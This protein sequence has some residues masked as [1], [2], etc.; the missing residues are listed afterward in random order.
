M[1]KTFK[2][3]S[4]ILLL[5]G[6]MGFTGIGANVR[7]HNAAIQNEPTIEDTLKEFNWG[8]TAESELTEEEKNDFSRYSPVFQSLLTPEL[9]VELTKDAEEIKDLNAILSNGKLSDGEFVYGKESVFFVNDKRPFNLVYEIQDNAGNKYYGFIDLSECLANSVEKNIDDIAEKITE[10]LFSKLECACKGGVNLNY[11]FARALVNGE[12]RYNNALESL[13]A[14]IKLSDKGKETSNQLRKDA[15][16]KLTDKTYDYKKAK[17]ELNDERTFTLYTGDDV[18][19]A[20]R[21]DSGYSDKEQKHFCGN[22][23]FYTKTENPNFKQHISAANYVYK[24][25]EG[26]INFENVKYIIRTKVEEYLQR[27]PTEDITTNHPITNP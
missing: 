19:I 4:L 13:V 11:D 12:G 18:N 2:N 23:S 14:S 22:L 15:L 26:R 8:W 24:E 3:K 27:H 16:L 7:A 17:Y 5:A 6:I 20:M 25:E 10:E 21:L 1:L 9:A